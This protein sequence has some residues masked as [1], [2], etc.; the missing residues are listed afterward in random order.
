MLRMSKFGFCS[1]PVTRNYLAAIILVD[2]SKYSVPKILFP[3]GSTYYKVDSA[4]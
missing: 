2:Q 4:A 3:P 1:D